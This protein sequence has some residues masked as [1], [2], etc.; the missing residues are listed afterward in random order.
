MDAQQEQVQSW[1][2]RPGEPHKWFIRFERYKLLGS[3][4]SLFTAYQHEREEAGKPHTR[5]GAPQSW[6][7]A[8][9]K[10]EWESRAQAWDLEQIEIETAKWEERR[11]ILR[12]KEWQVSTSIVARVEEM[13]KFPLAAITRTHQDGDTT[14]Q[15]EI[16]PV[17]WSLR[18]APTMMDTASKLARLAAEMATSRGHL[19]VDNMTD[20]EIVEL[21][22]KELGTSPA[23][24]GKPAALP[25]D[26]S[27][28]QPTD[29]E[30]RSA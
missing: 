23:S 22:K 4:R 20:A 24:S 28:N 3:R 10:Y 9:I 13:L 26:S 11:A 8:S 12:E 2:Q 5:Q 30:Q 29:N 25:A 7:N 17:R 15:T 14:I 6:R 21:I 1:L 16:K 19:D 27:T 18:D